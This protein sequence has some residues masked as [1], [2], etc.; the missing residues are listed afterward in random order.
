M[1]VGSTFR[2]VGR[3]ETKSDLVANVELLL[4]MFGI[5]VSFGEYIGFVYNYLH[6]LSQV[7]SYKSLL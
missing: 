6:V 1:F 5:V 3:A 7:F 2:F 4:T